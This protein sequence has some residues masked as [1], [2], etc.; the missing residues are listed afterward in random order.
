MRH[1][2]R[3]T[4]CIMPAQLAQACPP[5]HLNPCSREAVSALTFLALGVELEDHLLAF[6]QGPI[7]AVLCW[8]KCCQL[9]YPTK[10][11]TSCLTYSHCA[12]NHIY[13]LASVVWRYVAFAVRV[14]VVDDLA[15]ADAG[16][17]VHVAFV[18]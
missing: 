2:P 5:F 18:T 6:F 8:E 1:R 15:D 12:G 11:S 9:D 17:F 7:A 16:G 4:S 3:D 10:Y 13:D 14:V